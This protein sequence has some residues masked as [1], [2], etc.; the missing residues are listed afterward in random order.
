MPATATARPSLR[1]RRRISAGVS[2]VLLLASP[3][4]STTFHCVPSLPARCRHL[5]P[6]Y[7]AP[8][9]DAGGGPDADRYQ[10]VAALRSDDD[11]NPLEESVE[12]GADEREFELNLGRAIDT[13]RADYQLLLTAPPGFDIYAEH[14][15]ASDPGGVWGG[16][17]G[18]VRARQLV[19]ARGRRRPL[20]RGAERSHVYPRVQ[21]GPGGHSGQL[22]RKRDAPVAVRDAARAGGRYLRV[23]IQP[24][25]QGK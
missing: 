7:A 12:E 8:D 5:R 14:I 10:P 25:R 6:L 18:G 11:T 2:A 17:P 21:L 23:R 19:A 15:V 24:L 22:A 16:R 13:L 3:R 1:P 4:R 20:R 9:R